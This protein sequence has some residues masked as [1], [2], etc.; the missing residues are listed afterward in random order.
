MNKVDHGLI[1]VGRRPILTMDTIST[2]ILEQI[3]VAFEEDTRPALEQNLDEKNRLDIE[4]ARI[5]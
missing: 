5:N 2:P 4:I 3:K 1:N